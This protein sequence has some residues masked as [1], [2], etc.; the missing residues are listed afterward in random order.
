M[1]RKVFA[2]LLG[3][4]I[5]IILVGCSNQETIDSNGAENQQKIAKSVIEKGAKIISDVPASDLVEPSTD[6]QKVEEAKEVI[7]TEEKISES[8]TVQESKPADNIPE[9]QS[10]S[11]KTTSTSF[12]GL[13][14]A[15]EIA[16]IHAGISE[17]EAKFIE[18]ELD[19]DD[20]I[21]KYEISFN[22]GNFEYDYEINAET[23]KIISVEKEYDSIHD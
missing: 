11:T 21:K 22:H 9:K 23:G 12:I 13:E 3:F 8:S 1:K 19:C 10:S 18:A 4:V 5:S 7:K 2:V 17:S 16:F 6:K 20:Y 15:K 14:K